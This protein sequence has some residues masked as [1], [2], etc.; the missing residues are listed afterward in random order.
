MH[1]NT[2]GSN[3]LACAAAIATISVVLEE[4]LWEQAEEKG[5]Y[6]KSKLEELAGKF[7][8]IYTKITGRGLLLGQHFHN[9]EIGFQVA[10][11]LFHRDVL[12]AGTLTNA[13]TI[14]IEPPLVISYELIDKVLDRLE[15]TLK[16]V[17]K[18]VG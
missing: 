17:S 15:D 16:D 5:T 3:P 4:R 2:T 10:A 18:I 1:T 12:V 8:Q 11:G 14:R 7:P 13:Q 6:F 9:A